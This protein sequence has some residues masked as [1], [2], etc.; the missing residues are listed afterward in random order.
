MTRRR[1][2][3]AQRGKNGGRQRRVRP[4][5]I[6][7]ISLDI[8]YLVADALHRPDY[9]NNLPKAFQQQLPDKSWRQRL[10]SNVMEAIYGLD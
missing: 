3:D 10:P 6:S 9:I 4:C 5:L 8:H 1:N 7:T 2:K